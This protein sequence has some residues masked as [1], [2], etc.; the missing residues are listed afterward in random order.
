MVDEVEDDMDPALTVKEVA[1]LL[2]VN[3]R[4]VYRLV[5]RGDL[6]AFK[7]G[8]AWRLLQADV[9]AWIETQKSIAG[10]SVTGASKHSG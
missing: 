6:P 2:S 7:V 8:G 9:V 5:Q 4:T 10:P 1:E 3:E